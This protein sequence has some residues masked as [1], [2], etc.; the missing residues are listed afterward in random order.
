V[1]VTYTLDL[2]GSLVVKV[3]AVG[4]HG[5][6][7]N[8][9]PIPVNVE[10]WLGSPPPPPRRLAS[11]HRLGRGRLVSL[12]VPFYEDDVLYLC[13]GHSDQKK[14]G[15]REGC[16][17]YRLCIEARPIPLR[18]RALPPV[19]RSCARTGAVSLQRPVP[20]GSAGYVLRVYEPSSQMPDAAFS[21]RA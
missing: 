4:P 1:A 5:A 10:V 6:Y 17:G 12:Q 15:L 16:R 20:P 11:P 14:K 18:S 2:A 19:F 21:A 8:E 9:R 13:D 3:K 7:C